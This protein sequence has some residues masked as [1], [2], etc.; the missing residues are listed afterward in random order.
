MALFD[1]WGYVWILPLAVLLL[2]ARTIGRDRAV[3]TM[4]LLTAWITFVHYVSYVLYPGEV[5]Q[6][7]P[8]WG[9]RVPYRL[10]FSARARRHA[11]AAPPG[12]GAGGHGCPR[13]AAS[14]RERK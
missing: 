6:H 8:L 3:V 2:R 12:H 13:R 11:G 9:D 1:L 7:L 10:T 14:W 4:L 5:R